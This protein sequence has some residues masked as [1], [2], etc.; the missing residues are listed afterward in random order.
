M[1]PDD[2]M[3]MERAANGW[4]DHLVTHD[5][6]DFEPVRGPARFRDHQAGR[7]ATEA[8]IMSAEIHVSPYLPALLKA[9]A[10]KI[11]AKQAAEFFVERG[12]GGDP[13]RAM[14]L[15]RSTPDTEPASW[16]RQP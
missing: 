3:F 15:L 14:D 9:L 12:R 11:D 4:A 6:P 7:A 1:D 8:T 2:E 5:V 10:E 16:D 13:A